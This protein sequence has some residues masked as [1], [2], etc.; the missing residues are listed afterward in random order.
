MNFY[1]TLGVAKLL[2]TS[3]NGFR[4]ARKIQ[5]P[6]ITFEPCNT[7]A[8][9]TLMGQLWTLVTKMTPPPSLHEK[10]PCGSTWHAQTV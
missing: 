6:A 5:V 10:D 8:E 7:N 3:Q 9:L 4:G 2:L 1:G